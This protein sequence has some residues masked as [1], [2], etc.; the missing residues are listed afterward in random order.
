MQ[1][2]QISSLPT[3]FR[4]CKSMDGCPQCVAS[5]VSSSPLICFLRASSGSSVSWQVVLKIKPKNSESIEL[6][7]RLKCKCIYIILSITLIC[8]Y[9]HHYFNHI[10]IIIIIFQLVDYLFWLSDQ[11]CSQFYH[12]QLLSVIFFFKVY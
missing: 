7:P 5:S 3:M 10:I 1:H 11:F 4:E 8:Q 9:Y 12:H 6:D 2:L